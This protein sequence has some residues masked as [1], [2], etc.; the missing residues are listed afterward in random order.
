MKQALIFLTLLFPTFLAHAQPCHEVDL[1]KDSLENRIMYDYILDCY[2]KN[3]FKK[4][5]SIGIVSLTQYTDEKGR[6]TWLLSA[7]IDDS[8]KDYPTTKYDIFG[9]DI[10]LI[11]DADSKGK[12]IIPASTPE[13]LECLDEI[14]GDRVYIR[15][16]KRKKWVEHI[17]RVDG[18]R[19]QVKEKVT[20]DYI[21]GSG[22][23]NNDVIIIFNKDGTYIK[24]PIP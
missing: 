20:R 2:Q 23:F 7:T 8:F 18:K 16:A 10:V 17:E 5:K 11:Y 9:S 22:N 4:T 1:R 12:L 3:Y 19:I 6:K 21:A 13:L 15:P 24:E 14:I